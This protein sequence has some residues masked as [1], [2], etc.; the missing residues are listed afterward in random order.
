MP[1]IDVVIPEN[2]LSPEAETRLLKEV[3]DILITAE[4]FDPKNPIAQSVTLLFLHRPAAVFVGGERSTAPRYRVTTNVAEGKYSDEA[5]K[6]LMHEVNEAF[7]RAEGISPEAMGKKLYIFPT[8]TPEG[9]WGSQGVVRPVADIQAM[10]AGEQE[11]SV[12]HD[13]L[14][15]RRRIKAQEIVEGLADAVRR[16]NAVS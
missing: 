6:M 9:R 10:I 1:V 5:V 7:A 8:E 14:A 11:R 3:T 4:G 2:A 15:L 16:G 13:L 12:G